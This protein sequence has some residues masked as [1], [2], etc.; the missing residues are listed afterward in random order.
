M[1]KKDIKKKNKVKNV[2]N[3]DNENINNFSKNGF[4]TELFSGMSILKY[5]FIIY[6]L[7]VILYIFAISF[8]I[9]IFQE[10]S[11]WFIAFISGLVIYILYFLID[12]IYQNI[13]CEKKTFGKSLKNSVIN[14]LTPAIFVLTGYI[15][16]CLLRD[17]KKCNISYNSS[18]ES[19]I[20]INKINTDTTRLLN[21]HRNNII[22][23]SLFYIFSIIYNNP[24]NKKKC[25]NNRLC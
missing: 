6:W 13:I 22:V 17:V 21:I 9:F 10:E 18:I 24:I 5:K 2:K 19:S 14:A 15:F 12:I 3:Y 11:E 16:A 7:P 20:D 25:I 1:V 4:F 8:Y 23:A